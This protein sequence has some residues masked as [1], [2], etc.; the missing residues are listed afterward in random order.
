MERLVRLNPSFRVADTLVTR[1]MVP[2]IWYC[3]MLTIALRCPLIDFWG[4]STSFGKDALGLMQ[5]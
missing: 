3:A 1:R 4:V 5:L 2:D